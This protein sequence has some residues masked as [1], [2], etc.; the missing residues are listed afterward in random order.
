MAFTGELLGQLNVRSN[1]AAASYPEMRDTLA[2]L[3]ALSHAP[4]LGG[5]PTGPSARRRTACGT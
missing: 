1:D 4:G 3:I 2:Q 5:W